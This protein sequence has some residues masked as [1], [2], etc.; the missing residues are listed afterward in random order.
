MLKDAG[1]D[2]FS[3]PKQ[4][5]DF[6]PDQIENF[7]RIY[8]RH[9]TAAAR[10][11]DELRFLERFLRHRHWSAALDDQLTPQLPWPE[12]QL[13]RMSAPPPPSVDDLSTAKAIAA[14][15]PFPTTRA[16]AALVRLKLD[17]WTAHK[18]ATSAFHAADPELRAEAALVLTSWRVLSSVG[19]PRDDGRAIFEELQRSPFKVEAT[20]RLGLLGRE[21]KDL[22][23]EALASA[24][25][26]TAFGAALVLGDVDR[27]QAAL[28]G[29]D[30]EKIAAGQKLIALGVIQAVVETVE[31]SPLEVQRELVD[32]LARRKGP[33]PEAAD[34]LLQ[35][36]ETTD[37]KTL[38]ERAVR[39]LCRQLRPEWVLRLARA[40]K[41][42][43][44]IYQSLLQ[45]EG[46]APE[47]AVEF[48]DF[49]IAQGRFGLHQYGVSTLAEKSRMP[50]TFV[51]AKFATADE[52]TQGELLR[53]AE[54][55]LEHG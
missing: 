50:F 8:Q 3:V 32:A 10:H 11:V 16:L 24:D 22:L 20:V 42:D 7:S 45:A 27:L 18:D 23:R 54:L 28:R 6:D 47:S 15:S 26:E 39:V 37:D 53:F 36:A 33:A 35:I 44:S 43:T 5:K 52:K 30:L 55:Q 1:T 12:E 38:R 2:R 31:K 34:T 17:D 48:G 4:L 46:I 14:D 40:A 21:D 41:G 51:P 9:S 25:P 13:A 19:R 49:L 29:G